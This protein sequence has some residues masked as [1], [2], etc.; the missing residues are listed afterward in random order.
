[1]MAVSKRLQ[2]YDKC[3]IKE[4]DA[5]MEKDDESTKSFQVKPKIPVRLVLNDKTVS[6]YLDDTLT[7]KVVTF[8]LVESTIVRINGDKKCFKLKTNTKSNLF[9]QL[10]SDGGEFVEEWDYD[11]NLFKNQ[12]KKKRARS[13][14]ILPEEQKLEQE[15]K[16][17]VN[18]VK[19]EMIMEVANQNKKKVE[20]N[21]EI[22]LNKKVQHVQTTAMTAL[23]KEVKLEELIEREE[24]A[25]EDSETQVLETEIQAEKKKAECLNKVI[26]EK[27]ME[28]Q[29]N[30]SKA[31]A[32]ESIHKIQEQT[33]K[34]I[35]KKRLEIKK[36]IQEMRKKQ[37]RK[38]A[39]LK[40]EIMS[41]RTTIA[42][43]INK[44]SKNGNADNCLT[45]Q[46]DIHRQSYCGA[47]FVD[48]YIK[49]QDCLTEA[50]FCYVCCENEFG[51]FH[52]SER[53][54]CYASCD[55]L[56]ITP[57]SS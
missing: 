34:E 20:E 53:D 46:T 12:C 7:N 1:M 38:K 54:K 19:A 30:V 26:K 25:K 41:I 6:A 5:L 17:R 22:R 4:S 16:D 27:E 21:E 52:I 36:R 50:N 14:S 10:D 43:K 49:Y 39:T 55:S 23:S 3:Y 15:F 9:C 44:L 45:S 28:N 24:E 48:S 47:N 2:R 18:S 33:K 29:L 57:E 31:R 8:L 13:N 32:E 35:A 56:K 37:E 40:G 42:K 51:D 11:F